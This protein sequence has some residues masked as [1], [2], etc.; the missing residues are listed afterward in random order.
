M[1]GMEVYHKKTELQPGNGRKMHM[2]DDRKALAKGAV[3]ASGEHTQYTVVEEVGRGASCIVYSAAYE[4]TAGHRHLVRLKECYPY[5]LNIG[6]KPDGGLEVSPAFEESFADARKKFERAY[7]KNVALKNTLG[8]IN[9][10][11]DAVDLFACNHTWYSV[12]SCVEGKDYRSVTDENLQSLFVRMLA[13]ARIIKKYH[14]HGVLHLDIKPENI[15]LIPET[16]EHM[17][18]F[19]FD[20]LVEKAELAE[21]TAIRISFSDGYAAPELV[22]GYKNKICEATDIYSIGA[23][24]FD[25]LFGRTPTA[26]DGALGASYDFAQMKIKDERYQPDLFRKLSEFLHRTIASSISCR[27][28]NIDNLIPALEELIRISDIENIFL[29][30]SFSYHSACFVGRERELAQIREA[31]GSGRQ[32]LFLSG[33]GGIGKTELA[34]RYACENA[35]QYR[36]MVFLPFVDSVAETVCSND[37]H[38]HGIEQEEGESSEQYFMRKLMVLKTVVSPEDLVILDNFDV[39]C[40]DNL[41]DLLECPCRFLITTR[42]DFR[43]YDYPQ[44]DVGSLGEMEDLLRLFG[45]YNTEEYDREER[46]QIR[47]VIELV[48]RHTMT[49]E[50]M[51][52]YLRTTRERPRVLLDSLMEKEGITSTEDIGI[53]HRKDRRLRAESINRHLLALF[54]L[55]GFSAGQRELM[56]SMSLLGPVRIARERFCQYCAIENQEDELGSLIRRGWMEYDKDSDKLSLHQII[57]DLVYNHMQPSAENCPHIV[58]AMTGY[59]QQNLS[60]R[61]EKQ[62]QKRLLN[63]FIG[64]IQGENLAYGELCVCY[65]EKIRDKDK[66]RERAKKI[67]L[68]KPVKETGDL[69]QRIYRMEMWTAGQANDK[70]DRMMEEEDFDEDEYWEEKCTE[71]CRLAEESYA[72]ARGYREDGAY[73][74]IFCVE[75][76]WEMDAILTNHMDLMVLHERKD[77]LDK[78]LDFAV[79]LF[80]DGK[81]YLLES[82]LSLE[83]KR[84][85]VGRIQEFYNTSDYTAMYRCEYY[86]ST[87]TAYEYQQILESLRDPEDRTIYISSTQA[88][89][90]DLAEAARDRGEYEKAI[91][92]YQRAWQEGSEP[93]EIALRQCAHMYLE[94]GDRKAAI[95]SLEYVLEIDR[96]CKQEGNPYA[97]YTS[98]VCCELIDL[99]M[100]D[101]RQEEARQYSKELI[102]YNQEQAEGEGSA[103]YSKWLIAANYRLLQMEVFP[104][105][106]ERYW[107][108]CIRWFSRL[109]ENEKFSKEITGF[110]IELADCQERAEDK[111][112]MAFAF[113]DRAENRYE[114]ENTI[115]FLDYIR[116]LCGERPEYIRQQMRMMIGYGDALSDIYPQQEEEALAWALRAGETYEQSGLQ[117]EYLYSRIHKTIVKCYSNCSEYDY[118]QVWEE[119]RKCNYLLLAERDAEGKPKETQIE[120]WKE[121]ASDCHYADQDNMEEVCYDRLFRILDPIRN[122][123]PYS[124]FEPYEQ[125][126]SDQ[127]NCYIR[128]K[129]WQQAGERILEMYDMMAG[130]YGSIEGQEEVQKNQW[131]VQNKLLKYGEKLLEIQWEREGFA[132]YMAAIIAL[133]EQNVLRRWQDIRESMEKENGERMRS[134]VAKVLHGTVTSRNVDDIMD[135]YEKVKPILEREDELARELKGF[136]EELEW[137][138]ARYQHENIEFKR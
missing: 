6:R 87:E 62:V 95:E 34:K 121:A 138:W 124:G 112:E 3:V 119:R 89:L 31:F 99:L 108:E 1:A 68:Q 94:M 30:H 26:L 118:D 65:C 129:K 44:M 47:H 66:Y 131:L 83:E 110:L 41:E 106:K 136:A 77:Y 125:A 74:G 50:L 126:A 76:G 137:F 59:L 35:S 123:F 80:E 5:H 27:Y 15:F 10:T 127:I 103:Y 61:V 69:M 33:I 25:Q 19:D 135:I 120:L 52:K 91:E 82:D 11:M 58:E 8:L 100:E 88:D 86:G 42:E 55:S 130:H 39:D 107:K 128:Q 132:M 37:L 40:D 45:V 54:D 79:S 56:C 92:Y 113:L 109:P 72:C 49:V 17:V 57:L 116:E 4:D 93:Y 122:Q 38:I 101:G 2:I 84:R 85:W 51:A 104:E 71:I 134:M 36:K 111:M 117:D 63:G 46:A 13:L 18:L 114:A 133:V 73:L 48:D 28:K 29:Y 115:P 102:R 23:V 78:I 64:R 12:I 105:E 7:G 14:D 53:R 60:S 96:R 22:R 43:D 98:Y 97:T 32:V 20:S 24:V 9:S 67:C 75:L 70:F 16:K 21:G 90:G 81:G